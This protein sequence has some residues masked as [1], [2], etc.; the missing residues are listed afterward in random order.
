MDITAMLDDKGEV[1]FLGA[2]AIGIV[3][4]AERAERARNDGCHH[5]ILYWEVDCRRPRRERGLRQ[6]RP[7][8][9]HEDSGLP[10]AQG[11]KRSGRISQSLGPDRADDLQAPE[12]YRMHREH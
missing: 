11:E 9:L 2:E 10:A 8:R 3:G 1:W 12:V 7:G 5:P 4:S 6:R